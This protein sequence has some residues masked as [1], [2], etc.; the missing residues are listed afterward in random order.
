MRAN[1][2]IEFTDEDL[3]KHA[4]NLGRKLILDFIHAGIVHLKDP[5]LAATAVQAFSAALQ[6][7]IGKPS[8]IPGPVPMSVAEPVARPKL[9]KCMRLDEV[10]FADEA[11]V[12]CKCNTTNGVHRSVC[13]GCDHERCD[14]VVPPPPT[15]SA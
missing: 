13:R 2:N 5:T 4:R 12:C 15:G 11:W 10:A 1:I 9:D 7:A 8:P 14:V 3:I 6:S